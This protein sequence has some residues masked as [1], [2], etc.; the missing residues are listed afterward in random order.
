MG[1]ID[2][3]SNGWIPYWYLQSKRYEKIQHLDNG[4]KIKKELDYVFRLGSVIPI[5]SSYKKI[6]KIKKDIDLLYSYL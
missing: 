6:D 4:R 1:L 2:G 3:I 5:M